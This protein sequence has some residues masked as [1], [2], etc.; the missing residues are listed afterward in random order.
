MSFDGLELHVAVERMEGLRRNA[1]HYR[2]VQEAR[3]ARARRRR[4]G[5]W[6]RGI[7]LRLAATAQAMSDVLHAVTGPAWPV[8][9]AARPLVRR[10]PGR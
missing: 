8:G 5:L 1:D 10:S 4:L 3:G 6:R 2:L 9:D 7:A